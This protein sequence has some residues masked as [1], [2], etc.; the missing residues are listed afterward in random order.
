MRIEPQSGT[1]LVLRR[2]QTLRV[3][4]P[5][6]EQ[7]S[8]VLAFAFDDRAEWLSSGRTLDYNSTLLLT[9]GHILYSNRSRP[10]FTIVTD[11]VG[12]HDF[13]LAPC[14][15]EMFRLLHGIQGDHPSCF[16][17]LAGALAPYGISPDAIPVAFNV[18]MNVQFATDGRISVEP[19]LS[20]A[21]D[22]IDLR[23]DMDLVVAA[24]ACSAEQSN[25]GAFKPIDL[26]VID[27]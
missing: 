5:M 25:N 9:T 21:G 26:E 22:Q 10:M 3:I 8:D 16:A 23:A 18:F 12:R 11:T 17:N 14:S 1:A 27:G 4:D 7:V 20:R 24:T 15:P 13:T 6:G 2:G 19:P